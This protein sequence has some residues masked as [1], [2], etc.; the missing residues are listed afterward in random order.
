MFSSLASAIDG[1][2]LQ[3][4]ALW[5]LTTIPGFPPIIQTERLMCRSSRTGLQINNKTESCHEC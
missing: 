4:G 3:A 5:A 1:S 2:F